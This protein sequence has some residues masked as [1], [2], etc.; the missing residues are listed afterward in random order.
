MT[1]K[2]RKKCPI[3]SVIRKMQIKSTMRNHYKLRT[4]QLTMPSADHSVEHA[5]I[6][7]ITGGNAKLYRHFGKQRDYFLKS[8]VENIHLLYDPT[9]PLQGDTETHRF[10]TT[11]CKFLY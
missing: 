4:Y 2:D 11:S 10:N 8:N 7:C 6:S 3:P 1:T 5:E 9:T